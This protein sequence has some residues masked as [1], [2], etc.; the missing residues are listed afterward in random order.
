MST[1]ISTGESFIA[2]HRTSP[3]LAFVAASLLACGGGG[4]AAFPVAF[5]DVTG[6]F[7]GSFPAGTYVFTDQTRMA[8]AW[9]LA[10]QDFVT[11]DPR[12]PPGPVPMPVIDFASQSVIGVSLGVGLR[13]FV[14]QITGIT[15]SGINM[16]VRYTAPPDTGP[17]TLAC[18]RR[19][20]LTVFVT[21]PVLRGSVLFQVMNPL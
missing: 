20:P 4:D 6:S 16:T 21:V 9:A 12:L 15:G 11:P 17:V 10:P 8:A 3:L 5:Q 14:P 19:W 1:V 18:A 7:P 2:I 13:C